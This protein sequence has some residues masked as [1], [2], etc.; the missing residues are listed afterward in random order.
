MRTPL[1]GA[2]AALLLSIGVVPSMR[3]RQLNVTMSADSVGWVMDRVP[4]AHTSA[5][6][7]NHDRSTALAL[8]DTAIVVQFTDEGI[9]RMS[10]SAKGDS[11]EH[12][13]AARMLAGMVLG[14][15]Q[16]LFDHAIAYR[17]SDLRDAW[18]ADGRLH[19]VNRDGKDVFDG[20]KIN[21]RN[22]MDDFDPSEARRFAERV[23][24]ARARLR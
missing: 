18:Y 24:A 1:R 9:R 10:E 23:R 15:L 2:G 6:L 7:L 11:T 13:L 12:S 19:L 3:A 14:G 8:L 21:D 16:T 20:I 17:L 5:H 4:L 22:L